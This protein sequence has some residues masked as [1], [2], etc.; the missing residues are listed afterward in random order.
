MIDLVC[1]NPLHFSLLNVCMLLSSP[2]SSF[3]YF[4]PINSTCNNIITLQF[5]DEKSPASTKAL[6]LTRDTILYCTVQEKAIAEKETALLKE[7]ELSNRLRDKDYGPAIALAL[8]LKRPHR[9]WSVLRDAM[10]HGMGEEN[11]DAARGGDGERIDGPSWPYRS[12]GVLY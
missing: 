11:V 2:I 6:Q 1:F 10:T 4:G 3:L 5:Y 12:L 8:E 7:Q 9:L